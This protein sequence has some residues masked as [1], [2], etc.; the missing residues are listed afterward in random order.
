MI[1]FVV[2]SRGSHTVYDFRQPIRMDAAP[3]P[4]TRGHLVVGSGCGWF[5]EWM[6][7]PAHVQG[8]FANVHDPSSVFL[9]IHCLADGAA[10]R[11]N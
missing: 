1:W 5:P 10:T 11:D 9:M 3:E 2:P 4:M 6:T 7:A 8:W